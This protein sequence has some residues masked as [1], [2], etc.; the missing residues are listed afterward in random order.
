MNA[1]SATG[2]DHE[3]RRRWG[4]E[5]DDPVP[6]SHPKIRLCAAEQG[7]LVNGGDG[8]NE[9]VGE[10]SGD[11]LGHPDRDARRGEKYLLENGR[12]R[13]NPDY[14]PP[15]DISLEQAIAIPPM[16]GAAAALAPSIAGAAA[17]A[18][19]FARYGG[20]FKIGPNLKIAPFGNRTD[21]TTGK[22]PHYHRR[23]SANPPEGQGLKRHRPWDKNEKHDKSR[24][25][26]F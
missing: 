16:V 15:L 9:L 19:R 8:S 1:K 4:L 7:R 22:W 23:P 17:S 13:L 21:H 11:R 20:E 26:R 18:Y 12:Y 3:L 10:V 6:V 5:D 24:W 2:I 25:D 14:D